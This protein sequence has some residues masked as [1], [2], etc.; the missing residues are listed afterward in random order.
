MNKLEREQQNLVRVDDIISELEVQLAPLE[1]QSEKA[2]KYLA[3]KEELRQAEI[4][5]F[6][7]DV[8]RM[9]NQLKKL[10]D[11]YLLVQEQT[12]DYQQESEKS[13]E[14]AVSLRLQGEKL[15][16]LLQNQNESIAQL[17]EEKEKKEGEIRLA[18]EQKQNDEENI[19]RIQ[20]EISQMEAK[21]QEN[22][23]QRELANSRIT[24]LR[25]E[26][27]RL[28]EKLT[29]LEN[30]YASLST[31][32][33]QNETQA[34]SF[35]DEIYEQ[36][37]KGT[38]AKGEIAKIVAM[39][40]QFEG[41]RDQILVEKEQIEARLHQFEIHIQALKKQE[42][43]R[44]EAIRYLEQ[45][46]EALEQD[47]VH[48]MEVKS[49]AQTQL[50]AQE[51]NLSQIR[52]RLSLLKEMERDN[53]GYY[54]SVKALLNLPDR[55]QRGIC[56]AVGQLL[57]VEERF[58][59]A[60]EAALGAAV[61]NVVTKTEDNARDAIGY[62][63]QK[64]LGR[65]TFLPL[66]AIKG[67]TFDGTPLILNETGVIGVAHELIEFDEQYR[68]IAMSLLGRSIIVETLERA[69]ELAK[70]Y[71][72][73]YRMVTLEGDILNPGGAMTGGSAQKKANHLFGRG[74]EIRI[75][76]EKLKKEEAMASALQEKVELATEDLVE[77]EEENIEKKMELQKLFITQSSEHGEHDK[78]EEDKKDIEDR[79]HRIL[80]EEE[81]MDLQ[82]S[83]AVADAKACEEVARTSE[84][85]M[86]DVNVRLAQ[87]QDSL[88]E[89]RGKRDV[90]TEEI[91]QLKIELST[92]GQNI[93]SVKETLLRLDAEQNEKEKQ[94][95]TA[96]ERIQFYENSENRR[97]E[98]QETLRANAKDLQE[99]VEALQADLAKA[100]LEKGE[101]SR[102]ALLAEEKAQEHREGVTK[103]EN[104]IFRIETKRE[105][106]EEEKLRITTEI[107]DE[108]EMTY[109]MAKEYTQMLP[110][111]AE[112]RP[113]KEWRSK[114]REL[115]DVNVGAIEQYK[116]VRERYTFLTEQKADIIEAEEK[117]IGIIEQLTGLME[118]QF[119]T[120]FEKISENFSR[121]FR[122]L[123]GGGHAYL[124]LLNTE[125]VLESQI[126][127][128]AQPP[129]KNLQNMQLL[130]GGER[131]LT[132]IAILFSILEL[133][134]SPFCI[135]DEI[136]AALDDANVGR[137]AQYLRKFS[138]ETQFIV[139]THRK[140]TM[141]HADIL[142]GVT[143]QEKGVSKLISV[144]FSDGQVEQ[145]I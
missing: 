108:Y 25:M 62:L 99:Q 130:S 34:E 30:E 41:R 65:A 32:L 139:I 138:K 49:N 59:V 37:R 64:N 123:F 97:E 9:E 115:G 129:G 45:A 127:I 74:R 78:A 103:M 144:D 110:E 52:S 128:V 122:E 2:K 39:Q 18:Q 117:L 67:R 51:N 79:L 100:T 71:R 90:I 89:E 141:E 13:R 44:Q 113:V 63:K 11:D 133:K 68:Q 143:M 84:E 109:R 76:D 102:Q 88:S 132:A 81:Q 55:E 57:K 35:K 24:A 48:A 23:A 131:A 96:K 50:S 121:V 111:D 21:G 105:K 5:G 135:L 54:Q 106:M 19:A 118:E 43:D 28:Q 8:D 36:I 124:K 56:G 10:E 22:Q 15:D 27:D 85:T 26:M 14:E 125:S 116:E 29:G 114:I 119:S 46:L 31:T 72:H 83:R 93:Y 137:Y 4:T 94:I 75:L 53:E 136:E 70:K 95:G 145:V 134:P 58:E 77:I 16:E 126:E 1:S 38:E 101:A 47:R 42:E 7:K 20:E 6:C 140:G 112:K 12:K 69:V 120:Q 92:N 60:V 17:R 73:Q 80:L 142:Y 66:T 33:N 86:E 61:Q 91:T 3:L 87:F 98:T 40:G 107:W 82:I 104:E